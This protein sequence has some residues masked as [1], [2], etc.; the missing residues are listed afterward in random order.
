MNHDE[1]ATTTR[2]RYRSQIRAEI[3]DAALRQ[4][5]DGGP[6]AISINAIGKQLGASG[7]ALHRYFKKRDDLVTELVADA[8]TGLTAALEQAS[9]G[10]RSREAR[11][12]AVAGAYR[13]WAVAQP[14]RYR[15]LFGPPLPGHNAHDERLI[16]TAQGAMNVLL[17][18]L[19]AE[20]GSAGARPAPSRSLDKALRAWANT[21]GIDAAPGRSF[22]AIQLWWRLHG[23]VSLEIGG[24]FESMGLDGAE[25][26][27]AEISGA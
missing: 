8:Y 6:Q 14:H 3:K 12:R 23:L 11:L 16:D 13:G 24:N 4:L 19:P 10:R 22:R 15:L 17:A 25:L 21:R 2:E 5:A 18:A 20:P 1:P 27:D 9:E 26:L 7:P